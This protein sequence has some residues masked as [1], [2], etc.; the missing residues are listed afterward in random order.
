MFTKEDL[1]NASHK[2]I[3]CRRD[4]RP[5]YG[6][7]T[8]E[9][10]IQHHKCFPNHS[11]TI[12]ADVDNNVFFFTDDHCFGVGVLPARFVPTSH[13][14]PK[15]IVARPGLEDGIVSTVE[16]LIQIYEYDRKQIHTLDELVECLNTH[17][18]S[19]SP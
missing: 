11:V 19:P 9:Q 10:A 2:G 5:Y 14:L 7:I 15:K 4:G 18:E 13:R 17:Q 1:L 3:A 12:I 6:V 8:T 16:H